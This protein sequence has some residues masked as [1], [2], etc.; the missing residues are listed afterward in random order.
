MLTSSFYYVG[1]AG[2]E[3]GGD[4]NS[5]NVAGETMK[6]RNILAP[7]YKGFTEGHN[8]I[9]LLNARMLLESLQ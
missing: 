7:V 5:L 2:E 4:D 9:D 6:A 3:N 8:T 1:K